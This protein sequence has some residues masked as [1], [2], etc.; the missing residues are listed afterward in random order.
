MASLSIWLAAIRPKT[1]SLSVTPVIVGTALAYA[2]ARDIAWLP[3]MGAL[4]AAALIQAGTNLHNDVEDFE[5]GTDTAERLGPLRATA[6]GWI[7]AGKVRDASIFSFAMAVMLGIYLVFVGGWPIL[8]LGLLSL[9][10]A[11]AYSAGPY[12]I[13]SYPVGELF[14]FIF[15]GLAA[16]GGSYYLQA[17]ALS[18]N[19]LLAGSALGL[20]AAAVLVVNNYRDS[21]TDASSGR[22]TLA[23][24]IGPVASKM[25][26]ALLILT[27]FCLLPLMNLSGATGVSIVLPWLTLPWGLFLI[28]RIFQIPRSRRL[29]ALLAQTALLQT[30]FGA[31]L[32]LAAVS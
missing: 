20:L 17:L 5:S 28:Y 32:A 24:L 31:L 9:A 29:N 26:Y 27:P 15:F 10:A 7:E 19:S 13:S 1:L 3:F 8:A 22:R 14:V 4:L 12:P 11:V 18:G 23:V 6:Q 2:D 25:E 16:V 30:G 21:E